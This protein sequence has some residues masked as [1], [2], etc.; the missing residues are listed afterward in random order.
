MEDNLLTP[1]GTFEEK[2]IGCAGPF[3]CGT[4]EDAHFIIS[5][6][7]L[8]NSTI[9][10]TAIINDCCPCIK[11]AIGTCIKLCKGNQ[12]I[13]Q[14][15]TNLCGNYK[16]TGLVPGCYTLLGYRKGLCP[17]RKQIMINEENSIYMLHLLFD[18]DEKNDCD[19]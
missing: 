4:N 15:S 9:M 18:R 13:A 12:I 11:V 8:S 6:A 5:N 14:T 17:V 19:K 16:F 2:Q 7:N 3:C 1:L 10:G